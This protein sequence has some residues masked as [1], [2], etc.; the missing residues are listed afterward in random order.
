MI[1]RLA[2]TSTLSFL[3]FVLVAALG[4]CSSTSPPEQGDDD[5]DPP[6]RDTF[7]DPDTAPPEDTADTT[8]REDT[9][10]D[11]DTG[12]TDPDTGRM[13]TREFEDKLCAPGDTFFGQIGKRSSPKNPHYGG[14]PTTDSLQS[15]A[16]LQ[17]VIDEIKSIKSDKGG[18]WPTTTDDMGNQAPK[19]VELTGSDSIDITGAVVTS[20]SFKS[21]NFDKGQ[22]VFWLQ[23]AD[24]PILVFLDQPLGSPTIEVGARLDFTVTGVKLFSGKPEITKMSDVSVQ[25][26]ADDSVPYVD[27]T[28]RS[29]DEDDWAKIVRIGG[30]VIREKSDCPGLPDGHCYVLEHGQSEETIEF[31]VDMGTYQ[32]GDCVTF[33]GPLSLF[34]GPLAS[35]DKTPQLEEKNFDW[36]LLAN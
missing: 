22:Q 18:S 27:A 4:G 33:A 14:T 34:P 32:V 17:S 36:T 19:T 13:D 2:R 10:S 24:T 3:G 28:G 35:G 16:G 12:P 25:Q 5:N 26:N 1:G 21:N 7:Q 8:S 30:Q 9:T 11:P 29:L 15:S 31:R 20:T 6:K 23:D